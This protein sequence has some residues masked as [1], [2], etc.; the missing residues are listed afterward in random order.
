[1][2]R[3]GVMLALPLGVLLVSPPPSLAW[4]GGPLYNVTDLDPKCAACHASVTKD[5]LRTEPAGLANY[6]FVENL[7][8]KAIEDGKG[9]YQPMAPADRQKLLA[10]P[11]TR[12]HLS[13]PGKDGEERHVELILGAVRSVEGK[14]THWVLSFQDCSELERLR[15]ELEKLRALAATP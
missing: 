13:T 7:H 5:Q 3:L 9:P 2:S 8:Y 11:G 14:L 1:M 6:L 10:D 12:W 4:S 15:R